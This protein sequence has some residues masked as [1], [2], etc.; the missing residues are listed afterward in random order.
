MGEIKWGKAA[1]EAYRGASLG[2]WRTRQSWL[3]LLSGCR[4]YPARLA[5]PCHSIGVFLVPAAGAERVFR[6]DKRVRG[7]VGGHPGTE[8]VLPGQAE[9]P[10]LH[11]EGAL[12]QPF[13]DPRHQG[14][15]GDLA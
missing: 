3:G 1:A 4:S 10:G 11:R 9:H 6:V 12:L 5:G 7:Q 14:E 2:P 8:L 15:E 13:Q